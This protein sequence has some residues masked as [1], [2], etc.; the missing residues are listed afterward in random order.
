MI[1]MFRKKKADRLHEK[2]TALDDPNATLGL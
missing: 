2:A 1:E